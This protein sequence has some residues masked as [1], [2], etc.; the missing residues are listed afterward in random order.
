MVTPH[1]AHAA[2]QL[3]DGRVLI[4]GGTDGREYANGPELTSAELYDPASGT[5]SATGNML[6]PQASF[7]PTLLRD[8]RILVGDL[9]EWSADVS[10]TKPVDTLAWYA[11]ARSGRRSA[12]ASH[13]ATGHST[14]ATSGTRR[15]SH[16][17]AKQA[18]TTMADTRTNMTNAGSARSRSR[19]AM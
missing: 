13:G 14:F 15:I 17:T 10:K 16:A 11:S 9:A 12:P 4:V 6:K 19:Y 3:L 2:V 18:G 1:Y 7:P 8:G 5:W